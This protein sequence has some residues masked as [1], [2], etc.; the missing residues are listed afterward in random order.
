MDLSNWILGCCGQQSQVIFKPS[1]NL[2]LTVL[3]RKIRSF[4]PSIE[5]EYKNKSNYQF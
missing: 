2:N 1:S 4:Q 3:Q 5:K